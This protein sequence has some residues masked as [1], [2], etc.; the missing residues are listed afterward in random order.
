MSGPGRRANA[1]PRGLQRKVCLLVEGVVARSPQ[2]AL[3]A[4]LIAELVGGGAQVV[5]PSEMRHGPRTA[6][7]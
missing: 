2:S 7:H 4:G 1:G 3:E 6:C 5:R